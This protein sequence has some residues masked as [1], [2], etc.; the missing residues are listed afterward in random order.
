MRRH[1]CSHQ[2]KR[3]A[4][5]RRGGGCG[6]DQGPK[7]LALAR[8]GGACYQRVGTV[9]TQVDAERAR[10]ADAEGGAQIACPCV[11]R[12]SRS[13]ARGGDRSSRS[14][15]PTRRGRSDALAS[16]LTSRIGASRRA[17]SSA[18]ASH[19]VGVGVFDAPPVTDVGGSVRLA[20]ACRVSMIALAWPGRSREL[21]PSQS[22][23]TSPSAASDSAALTAD[24]SS[25]HPRRATGGGGAGRACSSS[26][27]AA[28][29]D[30]KPTLPPPHQLLVPPGGPRRPRRPP[31]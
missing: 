5:G 4:T 11:P 23:A 26:R 16:S 9:I 21:R 30:L 25:R 14:S 10:G 15:N 2:Q 12:C 19:G 7:Q 17:P 1:P 13:A 29:P 28:P 20:G 27:V 24:R 22:A 8:P 3:K 18:T 31:R 6:G